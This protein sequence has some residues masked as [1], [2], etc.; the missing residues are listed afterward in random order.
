MESLES[1][2]GSDSLMLDY[3]KCAF[4]TNSVNSDYINVITFIEF[5]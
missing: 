5:S 2:L 4:K 3:R 1:D